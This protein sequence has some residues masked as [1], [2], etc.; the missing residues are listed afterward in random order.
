VIGVRLDGFAA[1]SHILCLGPALW[2]WVDDGDK[3][4]TIVFE[5]ARHVEL[6]ADAPEA[7]N[8]RSKDAHD[9]VS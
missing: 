8:G 4:E 2:K 1:P 6:P 9:R 3:L 5:D 7:D